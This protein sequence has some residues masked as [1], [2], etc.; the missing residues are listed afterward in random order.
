LLVPWDKPKVLA[1]LFSGG[2]PKAK[3]EL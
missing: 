3:Q 1:E 2:S